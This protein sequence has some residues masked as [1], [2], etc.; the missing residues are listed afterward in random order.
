M[1]AALAVPAKPVKKATQHAACAPQLPHGEHVANDQEHQRPNCRVCL[2]AAE[3]CQPVGQHVGA[4]A[5]RPQPRFAG[6]PPR[7]RHGGEH[8]LVPK[9]CGETINAFCP[10]VRKAGPVVGALGFCEGVLDHMLVTPKPHPG[11]VT[12]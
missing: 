9:G 3:Q 2:C 8:G 5:H 10:F 11:E 4:I 6:G 7:D 12:D 1:K